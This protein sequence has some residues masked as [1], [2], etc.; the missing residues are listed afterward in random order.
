MTTSPISGVH[1]SETRPEPTGDEEHLLLSR[2]RAGEDR[3]F[4]DLV[5]L[6]AGRMLAVARRMLHRE[7]D[8]Q[9]AV[10]E[11]FLSAFRSLDR[12]D[13]RSRLT[14]WL[15]RITVNACLMKLRSQRRRP[16]RAIED[17]LPK[18]AEDGHQAMPSRPWREEATCSA[19]STE[20]RELVRTKIDEL[21]EQ[22]RVVL[23]LRDLEELST[24][25]TA[26][27]MDMSVNAVKT[28][29]HRARQ[30]LRALLDPYFLEESSK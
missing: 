7:E 2:L 5:R 1:T 4:D 30:A 12:F 21:P 3:A 19:D 10:Q 13:G 18:F 24:E 8:A 23:V 17:L 9:D 15:H 20:V 28:R 26:E 29:L 14:T 11:A 27:A 6:A 22:Y 25:E 16:E